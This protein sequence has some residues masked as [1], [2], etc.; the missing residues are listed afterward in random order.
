LCQEVTSS[1]GPKKAREVGEQRTSF[2]LTNGVL[3]SKKPSMFRTDPMISW[4]AL[5]FQWLMGWLL[6]DRN[7]ACLERPLLAPVLVHGNLRSCGFDAQSR[8][9]IEWMT[10]R[11]DRV[12]FGCLAAL[13]M[14]WHGD[15]PSASRPAPPGKG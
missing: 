15:S 4:V 10:T 13:A 3:G 2:G 11:L 12:P 8:T 9:D 7:I 1:A 14:P 5:L 6:G